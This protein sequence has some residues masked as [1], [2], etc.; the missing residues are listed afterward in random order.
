MEE[1]P[2]TS[3]T[4]NLV[5][6]GIIFVVMILLFNLFYGKPRQTVLD[7]N[8]SEFIS[9]VENSQVLEVEALGRDLSWRD[10]QG[11][12]FKTYA[13]EDPEMIKILREK[14]VVI[15]A[16]KESDTSLLQ[17]L[18]SWAP[19][20]LLIGVWLFFMRQMQIGGGKALSFGK[21]K[22]KILT[23][24]HRRVTFQDVAV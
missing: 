23:K 6:W 9:A 12:R 13:P 10:K 5:F 4:K 3:L 18:L 7:K 8:Y 20:I 11:K 19:M 14:G 22:A 21:S 15:N 16:K 1:N 17:I 2:L 24:D